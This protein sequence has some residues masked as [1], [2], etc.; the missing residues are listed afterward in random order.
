MVRKKLDAIKSIQQRFEK[1]QPN[2][3]AKDIRSK[4]INKYRNFEVTNISPDSALFCRMPVR[5]AS[6]HSNALPAFKKERAR[7]IEENK[8][9]MDEILLSRALPKSSLLNQESTLITQLLQ[10]KN[11]KRD[12]SLRSMWKSNDNGPQ[13]TTGGGLVSKKNDNDSQ[14]T[15]VGGSFKKNDADN[16]P[17]PPIPS[18]GNGSGLFTKKNDDNGPQPPIPSFGNGCGLLT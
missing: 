13:S 2:G 16:G 12:T 5:Q 8:R 1:E 9:L 14:S 18:F 4:F 10:T 6:G 17:Q 11:T 7:I 15:N 3:R